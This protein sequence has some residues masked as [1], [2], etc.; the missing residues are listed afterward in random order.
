MNSKILE[1]E[2]EDLFKLFK[3]MTPEKRLVAFFNHSF[4]VYQL[5]QS[6]LSYRKGNSQTSLNNNSGGEKT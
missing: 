2:K 1:K 4:L 3:S 6:G 5:S